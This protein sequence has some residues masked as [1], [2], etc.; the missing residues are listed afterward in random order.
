MVKYYR[1]KKMNRHYFLV[2]VAIALSCLGLIFFSMLR[3][4]ASPITK[5]P[6]VAPP[7]LTP[8]KTSISGVGIVEPSSENIFIG[9]PINRLVDKVLASVGDKV[10]KGDVLFRLEARDLEANLL[11]REAAYQIARAKLQ[12]LKEYPRSDDLLVAEATTNSVKAEYDFAKHQYEMVRDL[13]DPRAISQEEINR[14]LSN[15][16]QAEAKWQQSQADLN[17]IK[18]GSWAPDLEIAR[19][20]VLEAEANMLAVKTEIQR[21]IIQAP[22]DGTVLQVKIHEGEFPPPDPFKVP[23]I[24]LGNIDELFLRVSIN[25][26]DISNFRKKSSAVAF[27]QGDATVKFP[28]EFVCL[29]PF[30]VYKQNLSNEIIEKVDTRVLQIIYRIKT[31]GHR[32]FVGQQMDVF[33]ESEYPHESDYAS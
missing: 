22:I 32:L 11:A 20:E 8:Y 27:L 5:E 6:S 26:F 29:E 23:M 28:L 7:P 24:I 19:L 12:K 25:Q 17:K 18:D 15:Y 3:E 30:L 9:T 13:P 31:N 1:V 16:K 33:I 4:I 2:I 21:T 14:R 10:K